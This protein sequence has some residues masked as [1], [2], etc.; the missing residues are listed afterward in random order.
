MIPDKAI[1]KILFKFSYESVFLGNLYL[2]FF[3][4]RS[5]I[6]NKINCFRYLM[7]ND[8]NKISN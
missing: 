4:V 7:N 8:R 1:N 5:I 6:E 2:D 3:S